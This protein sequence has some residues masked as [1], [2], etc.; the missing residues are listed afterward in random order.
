MEQCGI[1]KRGKR[2][3]KGVYWGDSKKQGKEQNERIKSCELDKNSYSDEG[4]PEK[5]LD[6]GET[7]R[8]LYGM[9]MELGEPNNEIM[10]R[11]YYNGEKIREISK[12]MDINISTVKTKLKRSRERLKEMVH[13]RRDG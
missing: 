12:A 9:I 8:M 2:Q 7:G 3:P 1:Y 4:N 13:E 6:R 10:I 11:Y 5:E